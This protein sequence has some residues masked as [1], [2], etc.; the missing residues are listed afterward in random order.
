ML[1]GSVLR[2]IERVRALRVQRLRTL[3]VDRRVP[4]CDTEALL[5]KGLSM[6]PRITLARVLPLIIVTISPATTG[7]PQVRP[8]SSTGVMAML[9]WLPGDTETVVV[10]QTPATRRKA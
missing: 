3:A 8:M 6:H 7:T 5:S 4:G 10:T 9:S 2:C 1:A